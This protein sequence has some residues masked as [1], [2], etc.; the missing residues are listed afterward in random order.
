MHV[1]AHAQS[2]TEVNQF[3]QNDAFRQIQQLQTGQALRF[4]PTHP[5]DQRV[6]AGLRADPH[7]DLPLTC[8]GRGLGGHGRPHTELWASNSGAVILGSQSL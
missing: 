8:G 4:P 3:Q 7:L 6:T 2:V 1:G 5:K